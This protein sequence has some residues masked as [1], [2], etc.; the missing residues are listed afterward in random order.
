MSYPYI[1]P[2]ILASE[3]DEA[4]KTRT[5]TIYKN[6]VYK[7][8]DLYT[9]KHEDASDSQNVQARNAISSD[10]NEPVDGAVLARHVQFRDAILRNHFQ[11]A[12]GDV[13]QAAADDSI[14]LEEGTFVYT[15]EVPEDFNDNTLKP[16]AE[17]IHRFLVFGALYDWYMQFGMFNQAE[18]YGRQLESIE[19]TLSSML[20]GASI[21]K[22]PLQ[23]FG[24]QKPM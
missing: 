5:V 14:T 9:H 6:K 7:D 10:S 22:R 4:S 16:I 3:V 20:R 8:I 17:F 23:P 15:F 18:G 11:F 1:R 12:L 19:D 24:P 13:V 2:V 21:A